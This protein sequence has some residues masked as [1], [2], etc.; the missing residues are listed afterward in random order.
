M[1]ITKDTYPI[2]EGVSG[3]WD[4]LSPTDL[5]EYDK[6]LEFAYNYIRASAKLE[7]LRRPGPARGIWESFSKVSLESLNNCMPEQ[8]A[9]YRPPGIPQEEE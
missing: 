2:N 3:Y 4:L 5:T 9:F 8:E 6:A 7:V 1:L